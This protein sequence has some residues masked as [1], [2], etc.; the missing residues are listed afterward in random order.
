MLMIVKMN[1]IESQLIV[2]GLSNQLDIFKSIQSPTSDG[3][4]MRKNVSG[5]K[6]SAAIPMNLISDPVSIGLRKV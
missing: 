2:F 1:Q 3:L 6:F 4:E 5:L